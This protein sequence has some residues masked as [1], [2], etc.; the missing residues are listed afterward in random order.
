M[1]MCIIL[2]EQLLNSEP[3][4]SEQVPLLIKMRRDQLALTKALESGDT[5]LG[6]L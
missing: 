2:I 4:A 6:K 3:R 1:I 5:D